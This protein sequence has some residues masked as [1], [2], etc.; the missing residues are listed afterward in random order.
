MLTETSLQRRRCGGALT[1]LALLLA[2]AAGGAGAQ[3]PTATPLAQP[4]QSYAD[5]VIGLPEVTY[6][7]IPDFHPLK[8]DLYV[9]P[10]T[11]PRGA[12]VVWVHGGGWGVGDPR[13]GNGGVRYQSWPEALAALAARGHLV[14]AINYRFTGEAKFPAQAQDVKAAVRWLRS[15]A[16]DYGADASRVIIWGGSA[17]GYLAALIG[18]SCGAAALEPPAPMRAGPPG[19]VQIKTDMAQSDCVQGVV[20]WYGP[21][22][23]ARMDAESLPHSMQQGPKGQRRRSRYSRA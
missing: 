16:A 17:G 6:Q 4:H 12:A 15:N 13:E 8:A 21:I 7:V 10:R 5:D 2:L 19:T 9:P 14:M 20:D 22:D 1:P 18:T 3:A 11:A 23:F